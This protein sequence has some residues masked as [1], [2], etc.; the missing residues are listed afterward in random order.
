MRE[1]TTLD[2]RIEIDEVS[3]KKMKGKVIITKSIPVISK[4]FLHIK[5][6]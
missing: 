2:W 6:F 1:R 4:D 3:E 5:T